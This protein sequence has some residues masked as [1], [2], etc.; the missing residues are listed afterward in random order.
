MTDEN[1]E[2]EEHKP[3]GF[4]GSPKKNTMHYVIEKNF[5]IKSGPHSHTNLMVD[6]RRFISFLGWSG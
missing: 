2:D 5:E 1:S 3:S 4:K 6:D